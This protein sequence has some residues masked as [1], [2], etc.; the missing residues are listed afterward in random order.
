MLFCTPGMYSIGTAPPFTQ[1]LE[2]A[3]LYIVI[4]IELDLDLAILTRT[5]GLLLV[6]VF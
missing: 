4:G 6:D 1:E 3:L 2:F 5:S